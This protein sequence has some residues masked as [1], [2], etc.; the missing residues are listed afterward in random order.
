MYIIWTGTLLTALDRAIDPAKVNDRGP[1]LYSSSIRK[2]TAYGL[3][4]L[5][6]LYVWNLLV[7]KVEHVVSAPRLKYS[8]SLALATSNPVLQT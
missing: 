2:N 7:F 1:A 8:T 5:S 3:G 4:W 6:I